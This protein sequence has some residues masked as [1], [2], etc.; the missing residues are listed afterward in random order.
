[1]N[2]ENLRAHADTMGIHILSADCGSGLFI[3]GETHEGVDTPP[4]IILPSGSD[5]E[6]M[7]LNLAH[8][9]GHA[10][11]GHRVGLKPRIILEIE[12]WHWATKALRGLV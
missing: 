12:A 8:E 6:T 3:P 2:L 11:L 7:T 1:M 4:V 5:A 10:A 9:L